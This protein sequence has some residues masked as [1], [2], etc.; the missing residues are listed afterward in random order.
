MTDIVVMAHGRPWSLRRLLDSITKLT[1]SDAAEL[2]IALDPGH[3]EQES[4]EREIRDTDWPS[5]RLTVLE[6]EEPLGLVGNF[7][8]C[9]ELTSSVGDMILLEDD[10]EVAPTA[11]QWATSA[12]EVY[13]DDPDVVG[14]SLNSL[15]FNGFTHHRFD[16]IPDGSAAFF[17]RIPWYQGMVITPEWWSVWTEPAP[18]AD[19]HPVFERFGSQEWFPDVARA[20]AASGR[21][22]AYPRVSHAINHGEPGVHFDTPTG[23]FQTPLERRWR[24]PELRRPRDSHARYDQY[25]E[26]EASVLCDLVPD[27]PADVTVDLTAER[28]LGPSGPVVT[29]RATADPSRSWGVQRRPLEENVIHGQP[30]TG[31]SLS[32]ADDVDRSRAGREHA[33]RTLELYERHGRRPSLRNVVKDRLRAGRGGRRQ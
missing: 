22:F 1:D 18:E 16:A 3:P 33:R 24:S 8:R 2:I 6:S 10:L 32:D 11:L 26:L 7:L 19:V 29:T 25:M 31:I 20:V 5:S 21:Y 14:V 4:V 12:L 13:R 28:T 30:G 9:G 15:W 27:L 23:W 17:L